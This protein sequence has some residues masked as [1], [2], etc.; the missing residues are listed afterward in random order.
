M[1]FGIGGHAGNWGLGTKH[2]LPATADSRY[3]WLRRVG[4]AG[5]GRDG[6]TVYAHVK[7]YGE[8]NSNSWDLPAQGEQPK[9]LFP[10][11]SSWWRWIS[12][13]SAEWRMKWKNNR[14]LFRSRPFYR[15]WKSLEQN[16]SR[17]VLRRTARRKAKEE[18][19]CWNSKGNTG[20]RSFI[21]RNVRKSFVLSVRIKTLMNLLPKQ[22]SPKPTIWQ[23]SL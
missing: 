16:H 13:H 23:T 6:S 18:K 2:L 17:P 4:H 21:C 7:T 9:R 14:R 19:F 5:K 12:S 1:N 3:C 11:R 10:R 8:R 22:P 20:A 15:R